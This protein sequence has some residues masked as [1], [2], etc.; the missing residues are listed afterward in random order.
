MKINYVIYSPPFNINSGGY[1][2]LHYLSEALHS[3]GIDC[4][5][6]TTHI[7]N[8]RWYARPLENVL[9]L[10]TNSGQNY[11]FLKFILWLRTWIR[12]PTIVRK[13]SRK[14]KKSYPEFIWNFLDKETTVVVYAENESGNPLQAKH[15]ARWIM[16]NPKDD[17]GDAKYS[18]NEHLF[19]YNDIYTVNDRYKNQIKGL[20]TAIDMNY[21][22]QIYTNHYAE[23]TGGAYIIRKGIHKPHD[24][25]PANFIK[26]D[27]EL[28][29]FTDKEKAQYFNGI[30]TFIS[31][32]P[33]S[34][35]S[36]QAALSGCE[37]IV[38]PDDEGEFSFEN[39][40]QSHRLHGVAY[41]LD[42]L[43]WAR[44]TLHLLP[45]ALQELN[46]KNLET[47]KNFKS[48]WENFFRLKV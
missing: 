29:K 17:L 27:D 44:E 19:L 12:I 40:K 2:A 34:F 10:D 38:I 42:D 15:I 22:L 28:F 47:I 24:K 33:A 46:Q 45:N 35:I 26:I 30:K 4:V 43:P 8:P 39:L 20:L 3:Q 11:Y 48:Y 13:I 41:G 5:Y 37:V 1:S 18:S 16:M 21:H 31:Y 32:D 23:R 36:V 6:I 7:T 25:H 9:S 14:I